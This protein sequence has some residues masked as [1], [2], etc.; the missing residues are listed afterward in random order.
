[1][2]LNEGQIREL[3]RLCN[4]EAIT[5]SSGPEEAGRVR[6]PRRPLQNGS[7]EAPVSSVD[8]KTHM[9]P[10][11]IPYSPGNSQRTDAEESTPVS[12]GLPHCHGCAT[13]HCDLQKSALNALANK[14]YSGALREAANEGWEA[15]WSFGT[16]V[17]QGNHPTSTECRSPKL[18]F[19]ILMNLASLAG[20]DTNTIDRLRR[21]LLIL[22]RQNTPL[23]DDEEH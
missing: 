8:V 6:V 10:W 7:D 5:H 20:W 1:M 13:G 18:T 12:S 16:R 11:F 17:A 15:L 21:N 14:N 23:P 3:A 2:A 19:C 9:A 4:G 22:L